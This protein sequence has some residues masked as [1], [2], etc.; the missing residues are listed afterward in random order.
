MFNIAQQVA[1]AALLQAEVIMELIILS[2]AIFFFGIVWAIICFL[3]HFIMFLR[4]PK[5]NCVRCG[6]PFRCFVNSIRPLCGKC[7]KAYKKA[8]KAEINRQPTTTK[9]SKCSGVGKIQEYKC[10]RCNG[11]GTNPRDEYNIFQSAEAVL[12]ESTLWK[13]F[14]EPETKD[15]SSVSQ[16]HFIEKLFSD[17]KPDNASQKKGPK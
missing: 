13:N 6:K 11:K 2:L 8:F 16:T 12:K 1:V 5:E 14:F 15:A 3:Y 17:T 7:K 4:E 10:T 9:C